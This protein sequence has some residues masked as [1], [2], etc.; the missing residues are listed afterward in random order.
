ME[1][2]S[3]IIGITNSDCPCTVEGLTPGEIESLK[4]SVSGLY[5]DELEGG[6]N[7][8][9]VQGVNNCQN[10]AQMSIKA[11]D[12]A[13][14]KLSSDIMVALSLKY[15]SAKSAFV[16][17]I[18]RPSYVSTLSADKKYQ[19]MRIQPNIGTDAV[20]AVNGF[21]IIA[22]RADTVKAMVISAARG[23]NQ[24]NIVFEQTVDLLPNVYTAVNIADLPE[25][26]LVIGGETMDYYFVWERGA[27]EARPKDVKIDCNCGSEA[28][29]FK[30]YAMVQGGQID[31][32][33]NLYGGAR[34][35]YSRGISLDVDIRCK[36]GN[37]ICREYDRENAIAVTMAWA[38]MYKTGEMLIE[39]VLNSGEINRYT[40]MNREYLW[41]K[42][43]H[44]RKEYD[45]RIEYLASVIDVS[46]S[47]C[48]ICRE[49][50]IF[51]GGILS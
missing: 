42:R 5:V 23:S 32:L 17:T 4:K 24:G 26:P 7:M 47:D 28:S 51:M 36:P 40:M 29:G 11:R 8:A 20:I 3:E 25:I 14:K 39:S 13:I 43:N 27:N 6:I 41:G 19:F 30:N 10:F 18:G 50:R 48:Y 21:R 15:K 44:F 37:L 16:G 34:E 35:N 33:S 45:G 1:C 38:T 2:L 12:T 22:D 31:D 46:S 49:N 9:G